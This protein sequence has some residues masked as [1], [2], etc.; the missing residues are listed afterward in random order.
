[1]QQRA[2]FVPLGKEETFVERVSGVTGLGV[3]TSSRLA[4]G[5]GNDSRI[6]HAEAFLRHRKQQWA[7]KALQR[8]RKAEKI[9]WPALQTLHKIASQ[10]KH[11]FAT[12]LEMRFLKICPTLLI[13]KD[14]FFRGFQENFAFEDQERDAC[15]K[16]LKTVFFAMD[17]SLTKQIDWRVFVAHLEILKQPTR[18]IKNRLE[19][20]IKIFEEPKVG[21]Y[22]LWVVA[23]SFALPHQKEFV[24]EEVHKA[25]V[26]EFPEFFA[27]DSILKT[28]SHAREFF[29]E[30]LKRKSII[31]EDEEQYERL[32]LL[33]SLEGTSMDRK[34][35]LSLLTNPNLADLL[36]RLSWDRVQADVRLNIRSIRLAESTERF[37]KID[38]SIRVLEAQNWFQ[39]F[40]RPNVL[41]RSFGR[42]AD[43]RRLSLAKN[44]AKSFSKKRSVSQAF[45]RLRVF[46]NQAQL[47]CIKKEVAKQFQTKKVLSRSWMAWQD[48]VLLA[49][50]SQTIQLEKARRLFR[51][52]YLENHFRALFEET[53]K[54]QKFRKIKAKWDFRA[55]KRRFINWKSSVKLILGQKLTEE[56]EA[57]KRQHEIINDVHEAFKRK[58]AKRE[59]DRLEMEQEFPQLEELRARREKEKRA[60][61]ALLESRAEKER[62]LKE[63][64][65]TRKKHKQAREEQQ[66]REIDAAFRMI[67]ETCEEE[68]RKE[69]LAF[70]DTSSGKEMLDRRAE[71]VQMEAE[72]VRRANITNQENKEEEWK[73]MFDPFSKTYFFFN[74]ETGER[75]AATQISIQEAMDIAKQNYLD[76]VVAKAK[77]DV[78]RARDEE[79][80]RKKEIWAARTLQSAWRTRTARNFVSMLTSQRWVKRIDPYSGQQFYYDLFT[81][82]SRWTKPLTLGKEDLRLPEWSL[83]FNE[84]INVWFFQNN[85]APWLSSQEKPLGHLPCFACNLQLKTHSCRTCQSHFC[86]DCF[87]Q[88]HEIGSDHDFARNSFAPESC[89]ICKQESAS[90]FCVEC[91]LNAFF[92]E[93]C[94]VMSHSNNPGRVNKKSTHQPPF[95]F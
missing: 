80:Q 34:K 47:C 51:S 19:A 1:M 8:R 94:H 62:L 30:I 40:L 17:E 91:G 68:A 92:C 7:S 42:W 35:A 41:R 83:V 93:K 69:A 71:E 20:M 57:G 63:Q 66:K 46:R 6:E 28:S 58:E 3:L 31:I 53:S 44:R 14:D 12:S 11:R 54:R 39:G 45:E 10:S 27:E 67:L 73:Q 84:T 87:E 90:K 13:G 75:I 2:H 85:R 60:R 25:L 78:F 4:N 65:E 26:V 37:Q 55:M 56:A 70:L 52:I 89:I 82:E 49:R 32:K 18:S 76:D 15:E 5:G 16:N 81:R 50:R 77:E 36:A 79:R 38:H 86:L 48:S 23:Q 88:T 22:A 21:F 95:S 61:E 43:I 72:R 64:E 9:K 74:P 59:R 24:F 33:E 29:D